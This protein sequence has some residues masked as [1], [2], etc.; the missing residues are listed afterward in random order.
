MVHSGRIIAHGTTEQFRAATDQRVSD[1][2][3]GRAPVKEDV[4][5]LL[6]S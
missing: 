5:T 3:E 2:I 1:F 6:N 4:E